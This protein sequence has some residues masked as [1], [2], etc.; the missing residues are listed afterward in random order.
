MKLRTLVSLVVCFASQIYLTSCNNS[1]K[2]NN[3]PFHGTATLAE[4]DTLL[5]KLQDLDTVDCKNLDKIVVINEKMRRIVEN[6]RFT[7][8]FDKLVKA[9]QQNEYQITFVFSED[10][11]IG[12][13]SWNTKM[14]CLGHSIKNI[15]LFKSN[16]KLHA[17]SLYGESMIYKEIASRKKSNNKTIYILSGETILRE[18]AINGYTI[19]NEHLVESSI[20][21][22]E[23]TYVDNTYN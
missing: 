4:M 17:T 13:F 19:A 20:P 9:Y 12:V 6:I 5:T 11:H 2:S 8:E 21:T 16:D 18:P 7:E 14:D 3:T 1:Y 15:A 10:K 22:I 23:E